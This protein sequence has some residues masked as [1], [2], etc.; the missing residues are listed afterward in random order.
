MIDWQYGP[1]LDRL[2]AAHIRQAR[3]TRAAVVAGMLTPSQFA[4]RRAKQNANFHARYER[5]MRMLKP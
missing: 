5:F 1:F 2:C 3:Q 4:V